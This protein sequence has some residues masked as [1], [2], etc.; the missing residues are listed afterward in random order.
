MRVIQIAKDGAIELS[1]MWMPTFIGQN[2]MILKELGT[3]WGKEFPQGV[4]TDPESLD[5]MHEFTIKWICEKF[6][7]PGLETYLR[8][9]ENVKEEDE[10]AVH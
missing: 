1:W 3:A 9:I 8:A 5:A 2:Y 10:D 6:P 7:I 4:Q